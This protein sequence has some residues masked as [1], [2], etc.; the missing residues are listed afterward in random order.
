LRKKKVRTTTSTAVTSPEVSALTPVK[1]PDAICDA[2]PCR[3]WARAATP[4][5]ICSLARLTGGPDSQLRIVSMPPTALLA[6]STDWETTGFTAT[7]NTPPSVSREV[8]MT[9]AAANPGGTR[10]LRS[11]AAGCHSTAE[12]IRASRTGRMPTQI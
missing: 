4:W 3:R 11:Q 10:R 6:N 12:R 2:L 5:S 9:A 1:T 7:A 8:P